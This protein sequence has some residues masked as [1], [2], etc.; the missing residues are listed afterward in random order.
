MQQELLEED[1]ENNRGNN[2]N[3]ERKNILD[4]LVTRFCNFFLPKQKNTLRESLEEILDDQDQSSSLEEAGERAII[5]NVLEFNEL[6]VEDIMI[7]RADIF[8][9]SDDIAVKSLKEKLLDKTYTR[10]PVY[11]ENLDKVSGFIHI[12]D[13]ARALFEDKEIKV[14]DIIR[15]TLFVPE[16]MKIS[17]LLI[18]M[19][20]SRVHIAIVVDEYGGTQGLV[21]L[22]DIIEEI[23][24]KIEDEHDEDTSMQKDLM[25]VDKEKYQVNARIRIEDFVEQTGIDLEVAEEDEE[26]YSTLAGYIY[27]ELGRIPVVGEV[28]PM[29]GRFEGEILEADARTVGKILVRR[30]KPKTKDKKIT[31]ENSDIPSI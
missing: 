6:D 20:Q 9:I 24:G 21:T 17:N 19:Q 10:I 15:K 26:E 3:N 4:K 5:K 29:N 14:R 12:K 1:T 8:A 23:V 11:E 25:L 18:K 7:P 22:E 31:I 2:L 27:S 28:I 13:I 30:R 16:S